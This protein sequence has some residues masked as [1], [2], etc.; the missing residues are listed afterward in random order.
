MTMQTP[1]TAKDALYAELLGDLTNIIDRCEALP[2]TIQEAEKNLQHTLSALENGSDKYRL[3][4][5][6]F[7]DEAKQEIKAYLDRATAKTAEEQKAAMQ[8]AARLAFKLEAASKADS[9]KDSLE[10][11]VQ[12]ISQEKSRRFSELL[13]ASGISS[14]VTSLFLLFYLHGR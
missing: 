6:S 5:N 11:A 7:N 1:R 4:I 13:I 2:L 3:A 10:K 14:A 12:S 8:E 9:L